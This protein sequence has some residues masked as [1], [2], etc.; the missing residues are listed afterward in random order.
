MTDRELL[1]MALDALNNFDKGNHGMRWQVPIIKALRSRLANEFNPD[2]N[3]VEALQESL[4]EHMAEIQRL[5]ARLAQHE[6]W[7][8][9]Y[10]GGKPNYTESCERCGEVNPAEIHTCTP[11][12]PE[13]EE[14]IKARKITFM[15]FTTTAKGG[16][17]GVDKSTA[18]PQSE[19]QGL[20]EGE[21]IDL[22]LSAF[23]LPEVSSETREKIHRD[24]VIAMNDQ[25]SRLMLFAAN[26]EAKL[27][28][29]NT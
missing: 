7:V 3:Q 8:K 10:S 9:T 19:W 27:K 26:I 24:L 13:P 6:P 4:R 2:W 20:T 21:T 11:K 18:Q 28:E 17:G 15:N 5:R 25:D 23:E 14:W 12:Q 22:A 1:Q 16:A 29:K